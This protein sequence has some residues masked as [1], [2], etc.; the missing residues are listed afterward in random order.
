MV[1]KIE[2]IWYFGIFPKHEIIIQ[3]NEVT[4]KTRN[5]VKVYLD[6]IWIKGW[7]IFSALEYFFM[8]DQFYSWVLC[9]EPLWNLTICYNID[10][11][12]KRCKIFDWSQW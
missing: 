6:S 4:G 8:A 9:V 2:K 3:I 10:V 5:P 12:D 1:Y 11:P 7:K